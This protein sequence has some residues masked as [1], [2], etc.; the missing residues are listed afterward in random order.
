MLRQ[1]L[2]TGVLLLCLVFLVTSC[3]RTDVALPATAPA[4]TS[5]PADLTCT[6]QRGKVV[7]TLEF[8]GR[9]TPV[10]EVPL[11]FKTP[12]YVKQ[13]HVKQGDR[14]SAG[15]L[16]AELETDDLLNQIAQAEVAL[17]SAQLLLSEAERT[18]EQQIARAEL[19][20]KVAQAGLTQAE[21]ANT[22]AITQAE[23][24]LALAQE[25][26]SRL[27]LIEDANAHAL[28]QAE[29]S[30]LLA[31]EQLTRTHSLQATYTAG[32]VRARVGVEQ[33][34]D[35][36]AQAE[37][38]HKEALE[39]H[40]E[41]QE[42]RDAYAR[43]LQQAEWNLEIAQAQYDQAVANQKV[44]Q[45]DL[46]IQEI[47][48]KQ[49]KS[50]LEQLEKSAASAYQSDLKIQEIAVKQAESELEQLGKGVDP[51]LTLAVQR[52][53]LELDWLQE[54][55]DPVLVNEV[56][57]AQLTLDLLR[58]HLA[59]AQIVAPVDGE[60]ISLSLHPGRPVE[61][62]RT[63]IIIGDP[64]AIEVRADLA[65]D[66]LENLAEG[67]KAT[68]VP[69]THPDRTWTGTIRYLP[70]SY[71]S[72]GNGESPAGADRSVHISLE[73][74]PGDFKIGALAH[75]VIVLEEKDD[76]LWL[77][78]AAIRSFQDR[79]FVILQDGDRQR[80]VDIEL[81]IEGQAQVEIL[82]GLEEGQ[83]VVAP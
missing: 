32:I 23:L 19:N 18:V 8:D 14:V 63:V 58:G 72:G 71:D 12:G 1:Y 79:T 27:T 53:Q 61:A 46:K 77:P 83:V 57:Q 29:L 82:K 36:V 2:G 49:A 75:V 50:E 4:L 69:S 43:A 55:V 35:Q 15:D 56:N 70:Y 66:Q 74:N 48:V 37:I 34:E 40:W 24:T 44:Y 42:V 80:R 7:K 45:S 3:N 64:S 25:Q 68:V 5:V 47:T 30:L 6:V 41:P 54:G 73:G 52:A 39:R 11:Y 13:V 65:D 22:Y 78:P 60:I 67:Q 76:A 31:Q 33:T 59:D 9:I 62:F 38:E 81:G 26:L 10:E 16:L 21:D 20:L 28:A 17:D 51:L